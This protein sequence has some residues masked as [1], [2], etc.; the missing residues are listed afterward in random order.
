MG[1]SMILQEVNDGDGLFRGIKMVV[2]DLCGTTVDEGDLVY[3]ALKNTLTMYQIEFEDK[4]FDDVYFR[5]STNLRI[6]RYFINKNGK[7]IVIED[8]INKLHQNIKEL[9]TDIES[10]V[11]AIKGSKDLFV[12]LRDNGIKVCLNS[13]YSDDIVK[14][15]IKKV[16]FEDIIDGYISGDKV[17]VGRPFPFMI[18]R[19]M[20][21]FNVDSAEYVVKV[22]DTVEDI[23]EG[24][25]AGVK[26]NVSVLTGVDSSDKLIRVRDCVIVD[27]VNDL[28]DNNYF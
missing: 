14:T 19:L 16:G 8:M 28:L 9:Y 21:E 26:K 1:N 12:K 18:Y 15:I 11:K 25:N 7:E 17:K 10:N 23:L 20:E 5:E 3:K 4:E 24:V 27:S 2:F 22:G 6:L 13:E